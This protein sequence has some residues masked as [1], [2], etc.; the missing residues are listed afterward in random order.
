MKLCAVLKE[1]R[2]ETINWTIFTKHGR[3]FNAL[4]VSRDLKTGDVSRFAT[5]F[6]S[7]EI[8]NR[9]FTDLLAR[10]YR[11]VAVKPE[12]TQNYLNL[13]RDELP[14]CLRVVGM[15]MDVSAC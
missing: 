6:A 3:C 15:A 11:R 10:G 13:M 8:G 7:A 4:Y 14:N 9:I 5:R 1:V 12:Q 2:S